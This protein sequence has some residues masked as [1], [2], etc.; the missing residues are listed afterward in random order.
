MKKIISY[1]LTIILWIILLTLAFKGIIYPVVILLIL[2]IGELLCVGLATGREYGHSACRCIIMC[3][4]F[5][6]FWW[7]PIKRIIA[8]DNLSDEDFIED[9]LQPWREI[10]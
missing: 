3:M 2:H 7:L 1:T 8:E 10:Q 4:L 6:F 5:G 9:G